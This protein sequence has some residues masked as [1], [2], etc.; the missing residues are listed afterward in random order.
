MPLKRFLEHKP[1]F[2]YRY[3][4]ELWKLA[5]VERWAAQHPFFGRWVKLDL[6]V[7][8]EDNDAII[9]PVQEVIHGTESVVLPYQILQP[10]IEKAGGHF[11]LNRCPC[12]NREGCSSYPRDFGCL[13][14]GE[15]TR[16]VSGKIGTPIDIAAAKKH[17]EKALE[18]GLIP[19]IVH[20]SFDA[21]LIGVPYHRML[22]ICFCC[23]CCCTVRH[24]LR[25]GPSTFDD[26]IQRLPGLTVTIDET[27][28][29]CG[30]CQAVC[31]VRA[32]NTFD[33][34]SVID[35]ELCKGCGL[36]ATICPE[37]APQLQMDEATDVVAIL[38]DRIRSRTE[39]GV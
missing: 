14:L 26:T 15:A 30:A 25:L 28:I 24:H 22:A 13:F 6:D 9:I 1:V 7:P 16:N 34:V 11:A 33:G 10:I 8:P 21:D 31:P 5:K 12:R 23:D 27:C 32:I 18:L 3:L 29:G 4:L 38:L 17:V 36:C 20:A 37:A 19:M 2:R 35:Q 39:I